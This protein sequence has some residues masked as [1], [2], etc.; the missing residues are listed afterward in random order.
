MTAPHPVAGS[1]A[2]RVEPIT[3]AHAVAVCAWRYPP[4]DDRY[5]MTAADPAALCAPDGGFVAVLAGSTL[6]A[7]RSFGADG[8]VP[9]WPYDD[10]A[11]DTGGGLRPDLVGRGLGRAVV[12]A[13]LASGRERFRP[14]AF[15]VT[16]AAENVRAL[17][18]V[19][20]LG[21]ADVGTF[22]ASRDGRPF[23]VLRRP[24]G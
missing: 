2:L 24:E 8:R 15:R 19:R 13:G 16:V 5:D 4:P 7:F 1:P 21:F 10:D 14:A 22:P 11:L 6:V 12:A 9:G 20:A 23:V 3:R 18:T 17:R